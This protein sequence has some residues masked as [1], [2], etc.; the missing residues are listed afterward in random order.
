[1]LQKLKILKN[2]YQKSYKKE[3][4]KKDG[5]IKYYMTFFNMLVLTNM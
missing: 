4:K 5:D 3:V 2:A 1:M